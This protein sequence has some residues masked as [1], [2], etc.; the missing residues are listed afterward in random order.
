MSA[1]ALIN[2]L[3]PPLWVVTAAHGDQ[4]GG[5][6]A[7][8]V[9][10]ASIVPDLPRMVVGLARQHHTHALADASGAM[11]LH[12]LTAA[13]VGWVW[14]FGMT[15]GRQCD[16]LSE[17]AWTPGPTGSPVLTDALGWLAC[18]VEARLDT[19][20]RTLF[21]VEVVA[22]GGPL[23][24]TPLTLKAMLALASPE[25]K[26]EMKRQYEADGAVDAAAIRAW[27]GRA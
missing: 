20:D 16:K 19:G 12:L 22:T 5:L 24:G 18:R 14:Q 13:Q 2:L 4:R 3:D 9:T 27:R 7:T 23:T 8:N 6:V 1:A 25:Q 15:T 11:T 26:A 17:L 21:L 10:S